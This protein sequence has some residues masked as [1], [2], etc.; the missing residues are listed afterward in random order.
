MQY[1][2]WNDKRDPK[3]PLLLYDILNSL[4]KK[5]TTHLVWAKFTQNI[6]QNT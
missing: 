3:E 5:T 1:M 6:S 2:P 4:W